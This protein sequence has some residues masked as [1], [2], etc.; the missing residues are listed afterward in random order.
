MDNVQDVKIGKFMILL[1]LVVYNNV[2]KIKLIHLFNIDV[3]VK[4]V[5]IEFLD[6]VRDVQLVL[7]MIKLM[8]CVFHKYVNKDFTKL[9]EYVELVHFI[10]I[11]IK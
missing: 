11:T 8:V 2:I 10:Y 3:F 9:M 1:L 7:L 4:K 6:I 5:S